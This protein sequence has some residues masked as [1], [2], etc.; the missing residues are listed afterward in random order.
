MILRYLYI[1]KLYYMDYPEVSPKKL[2]LIKTILFAVLL[3][4]FIILALS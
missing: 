4:G 2:V 1:T 3:V